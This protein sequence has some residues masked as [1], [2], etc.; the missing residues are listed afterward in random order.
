MR[1]TYCLTAATA[2]SEVKS[3]FPSAVKK[4][5]PCCLPRTKTWWMLLERLEP[6]TPMPFLP[7]A[8][9]FLPASV[10]SSQVVGGLAMPASL[11]SC[12]L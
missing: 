10:T 8:P 9:S 5:A 1:S 2:P 3:G 6:S 12:L 11:K 7:F 4:S